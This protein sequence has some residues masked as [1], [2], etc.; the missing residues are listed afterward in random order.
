MAANDNWH[1]CPGLT[2]SHPVFSST[3]LPPLKCLSTY[4]YQSPYSLNRIG[5][6]CKYD[7]WHEGRH[8]GY[9]SPSVGDV[10]WE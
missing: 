2:C 5:I 8:A 1:P 4:E 7:K 3:E 9:A 6:Q 10:F